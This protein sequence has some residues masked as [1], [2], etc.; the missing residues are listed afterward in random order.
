MKHLALCTAVLTTLALV[1]CG[2]DAGLGH[3]PP[4]DQ[5][6]QLTA[7]LEHG[8]DEARQEAAE[9][10]GEMGAEAEEAVPAL[11]DAV[12]D[13]V[14]EVS[15]AAADALQ[16]IGSDR[17]VEALLRQA[18]RMKRHQ[19]ARRRARLVWLLRRLA[20]RLERD[21]LPP[22]LDDEPCDW[23]WLAPPSD[24]HIQPCYEDGPPEPTEPPPEPTPEPTPEPSPEPEPTPEPTPVPDPTPEPTPDAG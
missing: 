4:A 13:P 11:E 24:V 22:E 9:E 12:E 7:A 15:D 18:H 8:D 21:L 5:V 10:L 1:G 17:A 3:S 14:P 20:D 2:T 23:D 16:K 19:R 6:G